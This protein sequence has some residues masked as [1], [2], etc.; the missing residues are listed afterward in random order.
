MLIEAV[1]V[2][3]TEGNLLVTENVL[4]MR[5][6]DPARVALVDFE[7][8]KDAFEDYSFSEEVYIGVSMDEV[9]EIMKRSKRGEAVE[10]LYDVE[11][12]RLI[13]RLLGPPERRFS[14]ST[15]DLEGEDTPMPSLEFAT[16][17][18][19]ESEVLSELVKDAEVVSDHIELHSESGVLKA[20]ATSDTREVEIKITAEDLT[21]EGRVSDFDVKEESRAVYTLRYLKDM[22]RASRIAHEVTIEYSSDMPLRLDFE[23]PVV[24]ETSE[25]DETVDATGRLTYFLA[26]RIEEE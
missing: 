15:L 4:A 23:F 13:F 5:S 14:I 9:K 22:A 26:P 16:R 11:K 20:K 8:P 24:S 10:I 18:K 7:L 12:G 2:V 21:N 19:I 1:S 17:I 3:I 6:M 25:G